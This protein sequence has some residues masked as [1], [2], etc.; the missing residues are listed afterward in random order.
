M[1][2]CIFRI[3]SVAETNPE[4]LCKAKV[5]DLV[6][7]SHG[8]I[9]ESMDHVPCCTEYIHLHQ[10]LLYPTL[11]FYNECALSCASSQSLPTVNHS[12]LLASNMKKE[13]SRTMTFHL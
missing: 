6:S 13:I 4:Y 7:P 1:S 10:G 3:R 5:R 11:I 9:V 2:A 12:H 8:D